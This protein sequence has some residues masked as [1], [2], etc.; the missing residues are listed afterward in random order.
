ME[1]DKVVKAMGKWLQ[2]N[3]DH[4]QGLTELI[5]DK[6]TGL[7]RKGVVALVTQDVHNRDII[8]NLYMDKITS[9]QNFQWQQQLR[10][11]WDEQLDDCCIRQVDAFIMYGHEYMG[12]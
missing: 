12:A 4:L 1:E 5:R 11:Y 9:I 7:Q 3:K 2:K 6:L 8:D 10:Y